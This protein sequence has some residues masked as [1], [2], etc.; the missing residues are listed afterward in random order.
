MLWYGLCGGCPYGDMTGAETAGV[1][2]NLII[3][4]KRNEAQIK[5]K[6]YKIHKK[7]L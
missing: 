5:L 7:E 6:F 4:K 3:T 1:G 2:G